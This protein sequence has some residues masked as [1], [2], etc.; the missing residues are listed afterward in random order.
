V[1]CKD[2]LFFLL[3]Q[4]NKKI[5]VVDCI[6]FVQYCITEEHFSFVLIKETKRS[7]LN[8]FIPKSSDVF[9]LSPACLL[10][11]RLGVAPSV[12]A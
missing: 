12:T 5:F 8:S 10:H 9:F 4:K 6:L 11:T 3:D 7:S 2:V 1:W